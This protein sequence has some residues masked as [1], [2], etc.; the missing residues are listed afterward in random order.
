MG[1][2]APTEGEVWVGPSIHLGHYAQQHDTLDPAI[3][4]LH[5]I[6]TL[7]PMREQEAVGFLGKFLFTYT[8]TQS[9]IGALSG[10]EKSRLQLARLMLG[11][12]NCLLLDEPTN[13]L[14]IASTEVLEDAL[15]GY[16]GT[17]IAVS[18]DRYFLDRVCTQIYELA[19]GELTVYGGRLQR[20]RGGESAPRRAPASATR[21][22]CTEKTATKAADRAP[23]LIGQHGRGG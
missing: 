3:T 19:D 18:H 14:D 4:P 20:V 11:G 8:Q 22:G 7:R 10:G 16:D 9:P 1:E 13:H 23:S 5:F 12:E 15:N 2:E 17:V 6:R 21:C